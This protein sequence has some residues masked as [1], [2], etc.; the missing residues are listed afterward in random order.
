MPRYVRRRA[1]LRAISIAG[2][3]A[4]IV[5]ASRLTATARPRRQTWVSRSFELRD[6]DPKLLPYYTTVVGP[7]TDNTPRDASGVVVRVING[8][9]YDHPV[10]QAQHM[11]FGLASYQVN[12][13]ERYLSDVVKHAERIMSYAIVVKGAAYVPYS[14]AFN[15]H[16]N[17]QWRLAA[18]WYS[19]MAQGQAL[20]AFSR[21]AAVTKDDRFRQFAVKL[22]E[23]FVKVNDQDA[24]WA[25]NVDAASALW[26][27]E[28]PHPHSP[29]RALNGHIF[30]IYGLYDYWQLTSSPAARD[31]AI[32]G[33]SAVATYIDSFR[34][35]GWISNYCLTHRATSVSYHRVHVTQLYQLFAYTGATI[36]A[37][38]ADLLILDY[39]TAQRGGH[40]EL[41]AGRHEL[42]E[43]PG[44]GT[45]TITTLAHDEEFTC[46]ER[47]KFPAAHG[48]Y[49]HVGFGSSDLKGKW[50]KEHPSRS[51]LKLLTDGYR[52]A[53]PRL[54]RF[55]TRGEYTAYQFDANGN[56]IQRYKRSL[57]AASAAHVTVR[58][59]GNGLLHYRI[60]DGIWAGWYMPS[61]DRLELL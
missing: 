23:S 25:P 9:S 4:P 26:F 40:A 13:D 30:A 8:K 20:G 24:P 41:A 15:L 14:F 33:I 47:A 45:P 53:Y 50:V 58:L 39:P 17:P 34:N 44:R 29:C 1:V 18:P 21:L 22:F 5:V 59:L 49:L 54:L 61:D 11:L 52:F 56:Y 46:D 35:S 6:V 38:K 60:A 36:F 7:L 31:H 42:W 2:L 10:L 27:E 32:G 3:A 48:I 51:R 57:N 37:Q 16:G 19:G 28:Y 12:G 43:T 55:R